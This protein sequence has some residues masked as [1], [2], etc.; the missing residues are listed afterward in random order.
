MLFSSALYFISTNETECVHEYESQRI[1]EDNTLR[2]IHIEL[3]L[4]IV[5]YSI[6]TFLSRVFMYKGK[7]MEQNWADASH[8]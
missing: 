5:K 3:A 8:E 6:T 1:G 7:Q 4:N 2:A